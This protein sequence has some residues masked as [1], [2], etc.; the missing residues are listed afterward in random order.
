MGINTLRIFCAALA[1]IFLL[2]CGT[3][4]SNVS[5]GNRAGV[6]HFGNGTEPQGL[7]P[8][9]VTGLPESHIVRALFE[10]LAVKNP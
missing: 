1:S 8:H 3:G 2:A 10:G 9:I 6:L 4:E 5:Q 7:D